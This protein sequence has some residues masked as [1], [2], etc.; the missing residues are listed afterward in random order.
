MFLS[1]YTAIAFVMFAVLFPVRTPCQGS[2]LECS[3]IPD[4][5]GKVRRYYD[6]QPFSVTLVERLTGSSIPVLYRRT[7]SML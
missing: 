5:K 2:E 1:R 3:S 7:Q 4:Y 6:I